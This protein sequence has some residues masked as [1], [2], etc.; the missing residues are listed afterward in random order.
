MSAPGAHRIRVW[1]LPTRVF[2]WTLAAGMVAAFVTVKIG[3]NAMVWHQRIGVSLLALI[4]FRLIWG[5][6][7]GRYARFAQF[8]RGP[9]A[10]VD[11]LR[12]RLP[13]APGHN[14]MGALSVIGLLSVVGFQTVSG[15]FTNDEIAFEGP[16]AAQVS[17]ATSALLTTLHRWNEKLILALVGLH[18]AAIV[19]YRL[20]HRLNL[21]R[22]MLDGDAEFGQAYPSSRDDAVSRILALAIAGACLWG[23][24]RLFA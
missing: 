23:S 15:L 20:R 2:H 21:V 22:P 8:I 1:D 24:W 9:R 12:G 14:P 4:A 18:I 10:L 5:V 17:S 6:V 11:Y 7:G 3:G 13:H 19:F 16:L